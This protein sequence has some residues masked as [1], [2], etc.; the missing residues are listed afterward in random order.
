[1]ARLTAS[2]TRG[3]Q[4][5]RMS[6]PHADVVEVTIAVDVDEVDAFAAVDE[7]RRL[8]DTAEN[9]GRAVDAAGNRLA[10]RA[11]AARCGNVIGS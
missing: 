11:N 7:D 8:V 5:P 1:M 10:A 9:A 6:G 2:T 3:W 4:W